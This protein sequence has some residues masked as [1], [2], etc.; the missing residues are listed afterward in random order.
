MTMYEDRNDTVIMTADALRERA[1]QGVVRD[2]SLAGGDF[3]GMDLNGV[4]FEQVD[5]RSADFT[6]CIL[7]DSSWENCQLQ[8]AC[9]DHAD[10]S[11]MSIVDCD[12]TQGSFVQTNLYSSWWQNCTMDGVV[13]TRADLSRTTAEQCRLAGV[14]LPETLSSILLTRCDLSSLDV[15][16]ARWFQVQVRD[17]SLPGA[18]FTSAVFEQTS[19]DGCTMPDSDFRGSKGDYVTFHACVL[20]QACFVDAHLPGAMFDQARLDRADFTRAFL[21]GARLYRANATEA[22]FAHANLEF[23]EASYLQAPAAQLN[24][25]AA[26]MLKVH[27]ADLTAATWQDCDRRTVLGDDV[28]LRI[29]ET[30]QPDARWLAP[31]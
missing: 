3:R 10:A 17:S 6:D 18:R 25:A 16:Q 28:E 14:R 20:T 13:F 31:H 27:A 7:T 8:E 9:F 23:V 24:G 19:F 15:S 1:D 26:H 22:C 2:V 5:A 4:R 11:G 30:W 12:V 29:A 21:Q